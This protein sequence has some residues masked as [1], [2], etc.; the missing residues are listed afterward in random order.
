VFLRS[1]FVSNPIHQFYKSPPLIDY[2]IKYGGVSATPLI[3]L[4]GM[5]SVPDILP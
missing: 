4:S 1:V 2:W 5:Q 3:D